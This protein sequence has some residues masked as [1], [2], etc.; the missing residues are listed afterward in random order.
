M[1]D[2]EKRLRQDL[3]PILEQTDPR[4]RLSAYHDMPYALFQYEPEEEWELRKQVSMLQTRLEQRGKRVHRISLA[5]CL[6]EAVRS[7]ASIEEWIESEKQNGTA[8]LVETIHNVL[9]ETN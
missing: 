9:A 5:E 8:I 1:N 2:L 3:E 7:Q 6:D 4:A